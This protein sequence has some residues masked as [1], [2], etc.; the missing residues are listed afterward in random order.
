MDRISEA[1]PLTTMTGEAAEHS[2]PDENIGQWLKRIG[3]TLADFTVE[4]VSR[5]ISVPLDN[6][7]VDCGF[8]THPGDNG[9]ESVEAARGG[10]D[11]TLNYPSFACEVY[12]VKQEI[13]AA[14]GIDPNGGCLCIGCLEKRI[15]RRLEPSDFLDYSG[16]NLLPVH[17]YTPR[18]ASRLFKLSRQQ[19]RALAVEEKRSKRRRRL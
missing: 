15:G 6:H 2:R 17:V 7:C 4:E 10:R 5:I 19:R 8:D 14:S 16:L 3:K 12:T 11:Y 18:L 9:R 13:W 1:A